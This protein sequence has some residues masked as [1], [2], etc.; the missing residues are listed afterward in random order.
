MGI[1]H[2]DGNPSNNNIYNI[3]EASDGQNHQNLKKHKKHNK[4]GF[5]GVETLCNGNLRKNP[6][7]SRIRLNGVAKYLGMFKTPEEA[8][9]AYLKAKREIHPFNTL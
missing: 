4:S 3:R 2:I 5:L 6:Y 9:E 1:D 8:H 7:S